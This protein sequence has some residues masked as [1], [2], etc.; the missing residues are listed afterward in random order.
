M[1]KKRLD[2]YKKFYRKY[3]WVIIDI[4]GVI[5]DYESCKEGCDYFG[6]PENHKVMK[7][8]KCPLKKG[9]REVM[10]F[11]RDVLKLKIR[12]WTSRV[13]EERLVTLDWLIKNKIPFDELVMEK[14]RGFIHID[15]LSYHFTDWAE[16]MAD[17]VE[18]VRGKKDGNESSDAR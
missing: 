5:T 8:D 10:Q 4:D 12:L 2:D 7:R 11:Y 18:I 16:T 9:A 14:P 1:S 6:Y 3:S 17:V 15:D 13:E